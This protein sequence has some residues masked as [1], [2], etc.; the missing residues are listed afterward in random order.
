M[1]FRRAKAE[2]LSQGRSLEGVAAANVYAVCRC[3]G[4]GRTLEEIS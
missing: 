2:D 3:N 4:L 1:L